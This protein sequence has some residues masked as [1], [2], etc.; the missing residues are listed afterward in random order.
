[1]HVWP[2]SPRIRDAG[3]D[4][5]VVHRHVDAGRADGDDDGVLLVRQQLLQRIA[6]RVAIAVHS[7]PDV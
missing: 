7:V 1:M 6:A 5:L 4:E 3:A 2:R